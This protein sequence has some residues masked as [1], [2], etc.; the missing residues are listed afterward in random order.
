MSRWDG[1]N[2]RTR[3]LYVWLIP[4]KHD[5]HARFSQIDA[6]AMAKLKTRSTPVQLIS[7]FVFYFI[8]YIN[9]GVSHTIRTLIINRDI[10]SRVLLW[11]SQVTVDRRF[12]WL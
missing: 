1:P 11:Y 3:G 10:E 8:L 7:F 2:R 9:K 6:M 5:E 4:N 12:S